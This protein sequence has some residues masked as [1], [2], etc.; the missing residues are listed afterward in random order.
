MYIVMHWSSCTVFM[1]VYGVMPSAQKKGE[2]HLEKKKKPKHSVQR[3]YTQKHSLQN[4]HS[5]K[6]NIF[7]GHLTLC[8]HVHRTWCRA[9]VFSLHLYHHCGAPQST[10]RPRHLCQ[11]VVCLLYPLSTTLPLAKHRHRGHRWGVGL[12]RANKVNYKHNH[13][14]KQ[15]IT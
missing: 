15:V 3:N 10:R 1:T 7:V 11:R 5:H 4:K 2:M 14:A 9:V 8:S 12:N 6:C 13:P